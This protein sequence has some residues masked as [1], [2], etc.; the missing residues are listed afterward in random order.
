MGGIAGGHSSGGDGTGPGGGKD[1]DG[2]FGGVFGQAFRSNTNVYANALLYPL[3]GGS[4]GSGSGSGGGGGGGGGGGAVLIAS[5]T[6]IVF[7]NCDYGE[8]VNALG[9][10]GANNDSA[11]G[12]GSGGAI[13]L[14]APTISG[15]GGLNTSSQSDSYG[16]A[17]S[18]GRI[19]LDCMDDY[20]Y[21]TLNYYGSFS[22]G[23]QMFVFKPNPPQLDITAAA[24]QTIPV[25]TANA[26]TV[27]LPFGAATNQL[28]TLS[29]QNFTNDVPVWIAVTPDTGPSANF[30]GVISNTGNPSTATF[31][32]VIPAGTISRIN[33]WNR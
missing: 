24:G 26:V 20:L 14:V 22:R 29:A 7:V 31:S 23:S 21:R 28:V 30:P 16:L 1:I 13:R 9:G 10:N 12:A 3:I 19:R 8:G 2:W 27:S 18:R 6:R 4:G 25:G 11:G 17:G 32:V 15:Y 5:N 33:A